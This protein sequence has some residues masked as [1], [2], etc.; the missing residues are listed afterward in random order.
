MIKQLSIKKYNRYV[1]IIY[2]YNNNTF[3]A[4]SLIDLRKTP[5]LIY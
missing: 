3:D 4:S 2:N 1:L 5:T